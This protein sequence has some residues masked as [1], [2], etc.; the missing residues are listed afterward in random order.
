[1][2]RHPAIRRHRA[3]GEAERRD[4]QT[5]AGINH[6]TKVNLSAACIARPRACLVLVRRA[7]GALTVEG[8]RRDRRLQRVH[9]HTRQPYPLAPPTTSRQRQ[10]RKGRATPDSSFSDPPCRVNHRPCPGRAARTRH[11]H[12]VARRARCGTGCS[13]RKRRAR[14]RAP[15]RGVTSTRWRRATRAMSAGASVTMAGLA[16]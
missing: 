12:A 4:K 11:P 9:T 3:R 5:A 7:R 15:R 1:V 10:R 2:I 6:W 14:R 8:A 16:N 13:E